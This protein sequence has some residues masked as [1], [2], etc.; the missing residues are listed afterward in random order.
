V[1]LRRT[2]VSLSLSDSVS[3]TAGCSGAEVG[4]ESAV[5][6]NS[7]LAGSGTSS[8][9]PRGPT[10]AHRPSPAKEASVLPSGSQHR[11]TP[12]SSGP[13]ASR[14]PRGWRGRGGRCSAYPCRRP[15]SCRRGTRPGRGKV[16]V[17]VLRRELVTSRPVAASQMQT[18][19]S[20]PSLPRRIC[21]PA[22]RRRRPRRTG[23]FEGPQQLPRR[24]VPNAH[25]L[26]L[27][28]GR[29]YGPWARRRHT[30]QLRQALEG[31]DQAAGADVPQSSDLSSATWS[32]PLPSG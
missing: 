32:K 22:T 3:T 4:E 31:P 16:A 25:R 11:A 21:R 5:G 18:T 20:L 29:R 7:P 26:V 24:R 12:T 23:A 27:A 28:A 19:Q 14:D 6:A 2:P 10:E 1:P 9:R 30:G 8:A 17:R 15:A 13:E